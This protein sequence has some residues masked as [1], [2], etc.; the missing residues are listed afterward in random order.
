MKTLN[1]YINESS[2]IN[3]LLFESVLEINESLSLQNVY[4][5]LFDKLYSENT[6]NEGN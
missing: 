5:S 6:I 3:D 1:N 4:E 2:I